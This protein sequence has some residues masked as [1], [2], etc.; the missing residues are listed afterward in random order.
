[1]L[2]LWVSLS[3]DWWWSPVTSIALDALYKTPWCW[4]RS[5]AKGEGSGRGWDGEIVYR[6]SGHEFEQT[7]RDGGGQ[8]SMERYSS[9]GCRVRH[10]LAT[11]QQQ[12]L[13]LQWVLLAHSLL[14]SLY[15]ALLF[16]RL[17][18][19]DKLRW[20]CQTLFFGV[21]KPLWMVTAA[22]KL[23]D[24]CPLEGKWWPT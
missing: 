7:P 5:K 14:W 10:N 4:E 15:P 11:E 20:Q 13:H 8:R 2:E 12:I 1:M 16:F 9:W 22:M 21:P 3:S 17:L 6:L 19:T 23:K 18:I 24:A